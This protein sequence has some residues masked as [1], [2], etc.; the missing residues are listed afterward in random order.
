MI[1]ALCYVLVTVGATFASSDCLAL[2]R[3]EASELHMGTKFTVVLYAADRE[4]ANRG[5]QAAFARIDQLDARL[6]DYRGDSELSRL[7]RPDAGTQAD[8]AS[9]PQR[10][11]DDLWRVL[12]HAQQLSGQTEGA[13]DVTVGPLTRL[14]RRAR[15]RHAMPSDE[16]LAHAR[17][18]VGYKYLLLDEASQSVTLLRPNMRLDLGAIAKGYAT[19]EALSCLRTCG[20]DRALVQGGGDMTIGLAPPQQRGWKVGVAPLEPTRRPSRFLWLEKCGI[21]TSGDAWQF[22][23]IE[24]RRYSHILDPRTGIGLIGQRSVTVVAPDGMTADSL[25]T[26]ASVLGPEKGLALIEQTAGASALF[27]HLVEGQVITHESGG[28]D[29]L[30]P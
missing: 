1:T 6:S 9:Q 22:V 24:G 17:A 23:Q 5:F 20:I 16:Q 18:A 2:E 19:D 27:V 12:K 21:A 3:Y 25:A 7:S 13:F 11:S 26:A 28:F 4:A 15:R 14:W 30:T 8:G 29:R 10:V